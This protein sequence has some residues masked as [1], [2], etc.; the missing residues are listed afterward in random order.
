MASDKRHHPLRTI[1]IC[2]GAAVGLVALASNVLFDFAL[3]PQAPFTMKKLIMKGNVDG[4]LDPKGGV[5]DPFFSTEAADWFKN[6]KQS[7]MLTAKDG[8]ELLGWQILNESATSHRHIILCHG[9]TGT[10]ADLVSFGYHFYQRGFNVLLPA[11]RAHER[12]EATSYIQ[13]GY[14]DSKD[15]VDWALKIVLSD[16]EAH[17][18]LMGT[19]MG[20]AEVMMAS[21]WDLPT[22]VTCIVEDCGYSSV[23]DQFSTQMHTMFHMPSFPLLNIVSLVCK[24]R[25]GYSF[26]EASSVTQLAKATVPMLFIHGTDDTFVPFS[27]L[28]TNYAACASKEKQMLAV[29]GAGHCMSSVTNP[30]LYWSTVDSFIEAHI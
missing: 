4:V 9:Y 24:A 10:P 2:T 18:V 15:L 7:V 20:G 25:A 1:G 8:T 11:A 30:E 5:P 13:M 23:W 19:S 17:I 29:K 21:G 12:N 6:N 22:N 26:E 14:Q 16:P 27:C 28:H 3:N